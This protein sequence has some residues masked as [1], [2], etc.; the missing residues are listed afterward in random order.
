VPAPAPYNSGANRLSGPDR[1]STAVAI[2]SRYSP[3][4]PVVYIAAGTNYPDALSAGPAAA[5]QG[6][7]LLLTPPSTLPAAVRAEIERLAP[8]LIVVAGG[9]G[10]VSPSVYS[11]LSSLA[12]EIRRDSGAN[13]YET[14]RVINERAF[15]G[16]ADAAY[17]ATGANFP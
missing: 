5:V 7:P 10:V 13:R 3:R 4:V 2:A 16:G 11:Q 6:G 12:P 8:D 1:Y 9:T 17:V 15:P 14:S